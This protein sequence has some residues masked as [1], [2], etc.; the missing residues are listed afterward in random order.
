MKPAN[1]EREKEKWAMPNSCRLEAN[2]SVA[3]NVIPTFV[4][5]GAGLAPCGTE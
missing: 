4:T 2:F 3:T 5:R 1:Q